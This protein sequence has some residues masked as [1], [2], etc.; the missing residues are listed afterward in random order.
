ML[1]SFPAVLQFR[2]I[3]RNLTVYQQLKSGILVPP[4]YTGRGCYQCS[5]PGDHLMDPSQGESLP[6][7]SR[8]LVF[9]T[10]KTSL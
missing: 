10:Y 8:F 1:A 4:Y 6:F 9:L 3:N 7:L 5:P 2:K